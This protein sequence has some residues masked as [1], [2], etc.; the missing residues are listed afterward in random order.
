[1][2]EAPDIPE[3]DDALAAEYVLRLLDAGAMRDAE[4]RVAN[5]A[6]FRALVLS[7]EAYFA[8]LADSIAGIEPPA[9]I[10]QQVLNRVAPAPRRSR[11]GFVLGALLGGLAAAAVAF[12]LLTPQL[13]GPA[14]VVPQYQAALVSAEGDLQI[15]AGYATEQAVLVVTRSAGGPRPGRVLE[16]WLIAEGAPAPVSLG[17]LPDAV[18]ASV[19]VP[20]E[21]AAALPGGTLAISD[22]PPGGSPTGAPTGEVLAAAPLTEL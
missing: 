8:G 17:V 14:P 19:S 18:E 21:L 5:D 11:R 10:R 16:L 9:R 4:N 2:S 3:E 12:V 22:E 15:T 7:W 13:R 20:T 1:M 6:A